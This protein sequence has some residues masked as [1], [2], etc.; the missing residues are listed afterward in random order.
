MNNSDAPYFE[1]HIFC[2]LN[3]RKPGATR[4]SCITSGAQPL[5]NYFKAR[6]KEL[7][8][9]GR[10]RVNKSGC[11]DR[12]EHGPVVVIYPQG[13]WYSYHSRDD[14]EEIITTHF[15]KGQIVERLRLPGRDN[16][17]AAK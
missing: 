13:V 5:F 12:C 9:H 11:L 15:E 7:G 2:C 6:M 14:V 17:P 8:Y 10:M 3:E 1:Q 4:G 16:D